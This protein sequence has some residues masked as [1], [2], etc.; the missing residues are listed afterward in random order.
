MFCC[1]DW[2]LPEWFGSVCGPFALE[3]G[4]SRWS[5][6][7]QTCQ[8]SFEGKN[9]KV[10]EGSRQWRNNI[11]M[12]GVSKDCSRGAERE[13]P[14]TW[15]YSN[16]KEQ[17]KAAT[18]MSFGAAFHLGW[19]A[20]RSKVGLSCKK[21]A[22]VQEIFPILLFCIS[23]FLKCK[24]TLSVIFPGPQSYFHLERD[25]KKK[26]FSCSI[27]VLLHWT[28]NCTL[29][30]NSQFLPRLSGTSV[31]LWTVAVLCNLPSGLWLG[32]MDGT[33]FIWC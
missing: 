27:E 24:N 6:T 17:Q 7:S 12:R 20:E 8:F 15:N 19:T 28:F 22:L 32:W 23:H 31:K 9:I 29:A 10:V 18:W 4:T 14:K 21:N 26:R 5:R 16:T 11:A 13:N 25:R 1:A 30:E 33:Q 2:G 3:Y